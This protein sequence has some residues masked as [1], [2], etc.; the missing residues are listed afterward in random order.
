MLFGAP[1]PELLRYSC[2]KIYGC[3]GVDGGSAARRAIYPPF[4]L[5][6]CPVFEFLPRRPLP[7]QAWFDSAN[8]RL[9][10]RSTANPSALN[11]L[12][13]WFRHSSLLLGQ[14]PILSCSQTILPY[15]AGDAGTCRLRRAR[16]RFGRRYYLPLAA[17]AG[18]VLVCQRP[19]AYRFSPRPPFGTADA[20][21]GD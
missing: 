1:R 6:S 11:R 15:G 21:A 2:F 12:F 14:L 17:I 19:F 8:K 3:L 7:R 9:R 20:Y 13:R 4:G 10:H 18:V 16:A 5:Y